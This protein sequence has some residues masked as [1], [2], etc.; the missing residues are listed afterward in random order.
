MNKRPK[1]DAGVNEWILDCIN[2][3]EYE[4]ISFD[5]VSSLMEFTAE[6]LLRREDKLIYY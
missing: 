4:S 2:H 3:P 6:V 5:A 1:P